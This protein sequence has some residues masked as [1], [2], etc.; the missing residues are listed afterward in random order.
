MKTT[1]LMA[2]A[3]TLLVLVGGA[4]AAETVPS[5]EGAVI[6]HTRSKPCWEIALRSLPL[7]C[8]QH[9]PTFSK[10]PLIFAASRCT[11][12]YRECSPPPKLLQCDGRR[13]YRQR[14]GA[15]ACYNQRKE[16]SGECRSAQPEA[17][18]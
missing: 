5:S 14:Y 16:H 17:G 13:A 3:L 2:G 15:F 7:F 1:K 8:V 11:M 18:G 12:M 6:T 9:S 4:A 10:Y